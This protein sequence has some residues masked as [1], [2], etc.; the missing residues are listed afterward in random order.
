MEWR[1]RRQ[2]FAKRRRAGRVAGTVVVV[3]ILVTGAVA[4][5]IVLPPLLSGPSSTTT[6]S[7]PVSSTQAPKCPSAVAA[8]A[9]RTRLGVVAW[10]KQGSLQLLDLDACMHRTLVKEDATPP[11]RFSADGHWVAFGRGSVV[12]AS[13]GDVL[14]P[15]GHVPTWQWAPDGD[16]IAGVTENGSLVLSDPNGH[17]RTLLPAG[18]GVGHLAFSPDGGHLAVDLGGDR[19]DVVDVRSASAPTIYRAGRKAPPEVAGWSPD[20][21]WVLFWS[22]LR[23]RTAVPLNAVPADGGDW[24]NVFTPMLP[25][26][27]FLSPCGHDVAFSGGGTRFPSKGNQILLSTQGPWRFHNL[28][29]DFL[30]S[31]IWPAC[32]PDGRWIAATATPNHREEPPGYGVRSLW[33]LSTQSKRRHRLVGDPTVAAEAPRWSS[34]GAFVLFVRR[35]LLPGDSGSL[36]LL[37]INPRSG[38]PG[39]VVGPVA[40]L[41]PAPGPG[42][43]TNWT[44]VSDWHRATPPSG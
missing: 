35:G 39:D 13:G 4:A 20:G 3:A 27:D 34:D 44:V 9:S 37:A 6:P 14:H 33:L 23:G 11:V 18:S 38:E 31:W 25:F 10:V 2:V 8:T 7:P 26:A 16:R 28:S 24:Q 43:H 32:S 36:M 17:S 42:G 1:S 12:P 5:I 22:H 41:G 30:R 21:R 19:I 15:L 40:H 29:A